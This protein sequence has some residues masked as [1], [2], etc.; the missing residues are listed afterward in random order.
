MPE[1][2]SPLQPVERDGRW[3]LSGVVADRRT[4]AP[5]GRLHW[6]VGAH[7]FGIDDTYGQ[8]VLARAY[9]DPARDDDPRGRGDVDYLG[10]QQF[11]QVLCDGVPVPPDSY[12]G[13]FADRGPYAA[14]DHSF[15]DFMGPADAL[16]TDDTATHA[17][18][19]FYAYTGLLP[20]PVSAAREYGTYPRRNGVLLFPAEA[21]AP[22]QALC[23]SLVAAVSPELLT[24]A[25]L[26]PLL[27]LAAFDRTLKRAEDGGTHLSAFEFGLAD[28]VRRDQFGGLR[29][30][31]LA[32]QVIGPYLLVQNP[33][34]DWFCVAPDAAGTEI[35]LFRLGAADVEDARRAAWL[36]SLW[37]MAEFTQAGAEVDTRRVVADLDSSVLP[38]LGPVWTPR[39]PAAGGVEIVPPEFGAEDVAV[40]WRYTTYLFAA[41]PRQAGSA[42]GPLG[43]LRPLH[44]FTW[45]VCQQVDRYGERLVATSVRPPRLLTEFP[46]MAALRRYHE[47]VARH[48]GNP[49][50]APAIDAA[51]FTAAGVP[52]LAFGAG[53]KLTALD[54]G[55]AA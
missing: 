11:V 7:F 53:R 49:S 8:P 34:A 55:A 4:L 25:D 33:G 9:Y 3:Q 17:L 52:P 21:G 44:G 5:L 50:A 15:V 45:S 46:A 10:Y 54:D 14:A 1:R 38:G 41:G 31:D 23:A 16:T 36:R 22:D 37:R 20:A 6:Q 30:G 28:L 47:Q 26:R 39:S 19:P 35:E 29:P 27:T 32:G 42:G 18:H 40:E 43:E 13:P 2:G 48:T 12:G 24:A 51:A